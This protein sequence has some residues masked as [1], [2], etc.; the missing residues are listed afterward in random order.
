MSAREPLIECAFGRTYLQ[1]FLMR[2]L[3][4]LFPAMMLFGGGCAQY[5]YSPNFIH[6]PQIDQK[7]AAV[8][9]AA[10]SGSPTSINGDFHVSYSPINHCILMANFF[11]ASSSF[12][13][14]NFFG[15]PVLR[16]K[17]S[18]YLAE[19]AIGGYT[20]LAF[21]TGALYAGWGKGSMENDFGIDR[22]AR[23][24]LERFFIQPTFTFKND[25]FRLGMGMKIVRLSFPSGNIDYRIEPADI[26]I[27][28]RL[29]QESPIWFPEFGGNIGFYFKPITISAHLVLVTSKPVSVYGF[30]GSNMGIG[31]SLELEDV[32][33]KRTKKTPKQ[34]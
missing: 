7:N 16:K 31:I 12:T 28:Q 9:T 32:V 29:E 1:T 22:I 13:E 8:L 30:D 18:G 5:H 21:G 3:C 17:T 33:K 20:P 34:K 14:S 19:A 6:T 11:R 4:L 10:A 23:L 15:G 26:Q 27:I 24:G 25:W 2:L